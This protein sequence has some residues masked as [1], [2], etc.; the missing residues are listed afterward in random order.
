MP[1]EQPKKW[2]KKDKKKYIEIY[3]KNEIELQEMKNVIFKIKNETSIDGL[4]RWRDTAEK[5]II[6][7]EDSSEESKQNSVQSGGGGNY[8]NRHWKQNV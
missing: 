3:E 7:H 2:Q 1:W 6:E 4:N 5:G 8:V